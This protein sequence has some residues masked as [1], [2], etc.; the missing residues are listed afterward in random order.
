MQEREK[1]IALQG[2]VKV[3][4]CVKPTNGPSESPTLRQGDPL[5][6]TWNGG[7]WKVDLTNGQLEEPAGRVW[8]FDNIIHG[9]SPDFRNEVCFS[10]FFDRRFCFFAVFIR[11]FFLCFLLRLFFSSCKISMTRKAKVWSG[12]KD[13]VTSFLGGQN[14]CILAYGRTGS[15]KTFTVRHALA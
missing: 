14:G 9:G 10:F 13:V 15:G 6:V 2:Y 11:S 1:R 8:A 5:Q 7:D 12:V 4:C 3:T